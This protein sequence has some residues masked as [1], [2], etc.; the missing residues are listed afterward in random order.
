MDFKLYL[1][2]LQGCSDSTPMMFM[3]PSSVQPSHLLYSYCHFV[4][5]HNISFMLFFSFHSA[6]RD[7]GFLPKN[8]IICKGVASLRIIVHY[9]CP[10]PNPPFCVGFIDRYATQFSACQFQKKNKKNNR[11]KK[12]LAG[13][14]IFYSGTTNLYINNCGFSLEAVLSLAVTTSGN[15]IYKGVTKLPYRTEL[16]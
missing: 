1:G 16:V 4:C 14:G 8:L 2:L 5:I 10:S 11:K 13:I 3:T 12:H 15:G 9:G 7:R 6:G